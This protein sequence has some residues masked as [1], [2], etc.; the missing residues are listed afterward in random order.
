[1]RQK[2]V[3]RCVPTDV[4]VKL[5]IKIIARIAALCTPNLLARLYITRKYSSAVGARHGCMDTITRP[6]ITIENGVSIRDEI[7]D[8]RV[9]EQVL[10]TPF[11]SA[12]GQPDTSGLPAKMLFVISNSDLY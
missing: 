3:E 5:T 11:I 2:I 6:W 8:T 1:M 9:F 4:A 12:F 10:D 7:L